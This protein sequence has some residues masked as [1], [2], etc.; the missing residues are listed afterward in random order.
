MDIWVAIAPDNAA[1]LVDVFQRFGMRDAKLTPALFQEHGKI[2][3]MGVP[4]MRIEVLTTVDG[5]SFED[6]YAARVTTEIDGQEVQLISRK[7]LRVN[8]RASGRHKDLDDLEH[9]PED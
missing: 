7:H 6:C 4:P 2:V 5:V 3:R 8:K 9:L 1:K